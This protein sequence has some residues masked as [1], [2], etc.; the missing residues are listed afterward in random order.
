V[1]I[2]YSFSKLSPNVRVILL[3]ALIASLTIGIVA[4]AGYVTSNHITRTDPLPTPTPKPTVT[5][6]TTPE[7]T[8]TPAFTTVTLTAN[9]TGIMYGDKITFIAVLDQP[10]AGVE[11]T[12]Y[13]NSTSYGTY[14]TNSFGIATFTR[15][16][17]TGAYDIYVTAKQ[18]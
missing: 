8:Q 3:V 16:P 1:N 6:S 5:P 9:D 15:G 13:N 4:A 14:T 17:F 10:V 11:I 2:R 18:S 12:Y 7:P